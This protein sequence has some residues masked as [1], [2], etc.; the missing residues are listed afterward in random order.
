VTTGAGDAVRVSGVQ[1]VDAFLSKLLDVSLQVC[2]DFFQQRSADALAYH[3][4]V[5][6]AQAV[7]LRTKFM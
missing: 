4:L 7:L 2:P 5:L 6:P 1:S 3:Q